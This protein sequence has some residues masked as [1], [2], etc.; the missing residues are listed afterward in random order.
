MPKLKTNKGAKKRFKITKTGKVKRR[1]EGA[2]HILTKKTRKRKRSLKK[3][4]TVD[5]T[6][7]KKVK[8]LLPYE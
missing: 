7:E 5:K 6:M 2:R 8:N 4:T 3:A 1:K